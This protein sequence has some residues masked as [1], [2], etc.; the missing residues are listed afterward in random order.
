MGAFLMFTFVCVLLFGFYA[1]SAS[2][3]GMIGGAVVSSAA[4]LIPLV[5]PL[6][7]MFFI[8]GEKQKTE[9]RYVNPN[10]NI[11]N[12][13]EDIKLK[14]NYGKIISCKDKT[15][16]FNLT[17]YN[18]RLESSN[19][20]CFD[21]KNYEHDY[22]YKKISFSKITGCEMYKN[23]TIVDFLYKTKVEKPYDLMCD[24][25][26]IFYYDIS[27]SCKD[28]YVVLEFEDYVNDVFAIIKYIIENCKKWNYRT[29]WEDVLN[30]PIFENI[31]NPIQLQ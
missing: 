6:V 24:N 2:Q 28:N 1:I 18:G 20:Y 21:F 25:G 16:V 7:I 31:K 9:K 3:V 23:S 19:V 8:S 30:I 17:E 10:E 27:S 11:L 12:K 15:F 5:L 14:S 13:L 4:V 29:A 22:D 26:I